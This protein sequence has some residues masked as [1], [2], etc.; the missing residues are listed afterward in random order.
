L[1]ANWLV[2]LEFGGRALEY[3]LSV[4]HDVDAVRDLQSDRQLLFDQRIA[5][6]RRAISA[7]GLRSPS[8][9]FLAS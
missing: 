5:T 1:A 4:A 7:F 8:F 9:G 3:N 6:P 2:A